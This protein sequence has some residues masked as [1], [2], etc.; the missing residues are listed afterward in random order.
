MAIYCTIQ[1]YKDSDWKSFRKFDRKVENAG[2]TLYQM[3]KILDETKLK[4]FADGKLNIAKM[5]ISLFDRVENAVGKA[6]AFSKAFFFRVVESWDCV[7]K[8]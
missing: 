7:V 3:K 2:L 4:V 5:T 8:N 1:S 6:T